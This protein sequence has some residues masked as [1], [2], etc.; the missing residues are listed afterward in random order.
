MKISSP[1][2]LALCAVLAGDTPCLDAALLVASLNGSQVLRFHEAT[3][4][5]VGDGEL[6]GTGSADLGRPWGITIGPDGDLF[7]VS[8][9]T[10]TTPDRVLRFNPVTGAPVGSGVFVSD[11]S[12]APHGLSGLTFGPD[13][14]LYVTSYRTHEVRR[15]DGRTGAPIGSGVFVPAGSAGSLNPSDLQFGPDGNLYVGSGS[16]DQILRFDGVTGAP[17][18]D[19]VFVPAGSAGLDGPVGIRFGADGDLFVASTF[20]GDILRF[21][22]ITGDPVAGGVFVA[23]GTVGLSFPEFIQF[24]PSGHLFVGTWDGQRVLEFDGTT[25]LP[26]GSGTFVAS[27]SAGLDGPEGLVFTIRDPADFDDDGV[28]GC[29]DVDA[30]VAV[31]AGGT[32]DLSFDLTLDGLV[33]GADLQSWLAQ[34][35]ARNLASGNPYLPGDANLDSYVDGLDFIIWNAHKFTSTAAWCSGDFNADGFVDGLDFIIWNAHKFTSAD[36]GVRSVPEPGSLSVMAPFW[37]PPFGIGVAAAITIF[38]RFLTGAWNEQ[39]RTRPLSAATSRRI[40]GT[41]IDALQHVRRP[42]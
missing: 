36:A 8:E 30:L 29:A 4:G 35:G 20:S 18:G 40:A 3:G 25:G 11:S 10:D 2:L 34:A 26:F 5:A 9:S 16:S 17:L 38:T 7:V 24:G 1:V 21:D 42:R 33:N 28:S 27:G 14:N 37:A 19:G 22:G 15:Y 6:I 32:N 39:S 31:I 23:A 41:A 13:G 12:V